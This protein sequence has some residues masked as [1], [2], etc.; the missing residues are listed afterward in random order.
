M[1]DMPYSN[2][3][4]VTAVSEA[5]NCVELN[6]PP[7]GE[8]KRL[9]VSQMDGGPDGFTFRAYDR[10]DACPGQVQ[11]PERVGTSVPV[12]ET[13]P[14]SSH[15]LSPDYVA[16]AG[17]S[18]VALFDL[19]IPYTVKNAPNP[20]TVANKGGLTLW[21]RPNG[22]GNKRFAVSYTVLGLQTG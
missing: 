4:V 22:A 17:D 12:L 11:Q 6:L 2:A 3:V 14:R 8:L 20:A 16:A 18:E 5:D 15:Q 19:S 1:S 21:L 10:R 9:I 7:R 13:L